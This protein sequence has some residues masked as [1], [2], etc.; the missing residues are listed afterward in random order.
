MRF[1]ASTATVP[2][3]TFDARTYGGT[4]EFY[5]NAL[6]GYSVVGAATGSYSFSSAVSCVATGGGVV[7]VD[8]D[9]ATDATYTL[10]SSLTI[11][12]GCDFQ[13]PS[14][15]TIIV[16]GN[17]T[18][19]E[20]FTANAGTVQLSGTSSINGLTDTNFNNLIIGDN[21]YDT[22]TV[23]G[24][25]DP[26]V[27]GTLTFTQP[28][29]STNTLSISSGR[30]VTCTGSTDIAG[31]VGTVSGAGTIVFKSATTGGPG[32][33]VTLSSLIRFDATTAS[34]PAAVFDARTYGGGVEL[35]SAGGSART[36]TAID[37][38]T[39]TFSANVTTT[40]TGCTGGLVLDLD[41]VAD[42]TISVAGT[43]T[44]GASTTLQAPSS[45]T[46]TLGGNYTNSGT[47]THDSG[48]VQFTGADVAINGT[49][50]L[51]MI[52]LGFMMILYQIMLELSGNERFFK[53][54]IYS[55]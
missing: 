50:N 23:N 10:S 28:A 41:G 51:T 20:S 4:V 40:C 31:T 9:D 14:S 7:T 33:A 42:S 55:C 11:D 48:T 16:Q 12:V 37:S 6:A 2:A 52:F 38:A 53:T 54:F 45:T 44:I 5:I 35:Y 18:N 25:D 27:A 3:T 1:D 34:I 15:T 36:V 17:F 49:I 30:T 43:L 8:L 22:V 39:Y 26:I 46:L 47:F 29:A 13:A 32:T 24:T 21:T 19:N